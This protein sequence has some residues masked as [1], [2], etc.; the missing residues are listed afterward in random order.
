MSHRL[1]LLIV[2]SVAFGFCSGPRIDWDAISARTSDGRAQLHGLDA[3][4]RIPGEYV[5]R[6]WPDHTHEAHDRAI[7]KTT[8][9]FASFKRFSFGYQA[10]LSDQDLNELVRRDPGVRWVEANQHI[11][12]DEPVE[13]SAS[14]PNTVKTSTDQL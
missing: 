3:E 5:V 8:S 12:L 2:T 11:Y 7:G 14:E 4:E 13:E 10:S 1:L 9:D 6:F